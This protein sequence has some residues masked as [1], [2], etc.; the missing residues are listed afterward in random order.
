MVSEDIDL[1]L[2]IECPKCSVMMK[3]IV[4]T[5]PMTAVEVDHCQGCE[6]YWFDRYELVKVIDEKMDGP[7]PYENIEERGNI[8]VCPRCRGHIDTK[9]LWDIKVDLCNDCGG[10]WLDKGE[11]KEVQDKYRFEQNQ[12]KLIELLKSVLQE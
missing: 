8:A 11:L 10:I 5:T 1:G 9:S 3:Q 6:G 12:N 7:L 4:V 2:P